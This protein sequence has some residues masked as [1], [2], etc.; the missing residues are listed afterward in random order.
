MDITIKVNDDQFNDLM[1]EGIEALSI[2][3][4]KQILINGIT[5]M[6]ESSFGKEI[7]TKLLFKK[8]YYGSDYN[9]SDTGMKILSSCISDQDFTD[10]KEI[11][12]EKL[13]TNGDD[14]L[15]DAIMRIFMQGF[16]KS[17]EVQQAISNTTEEYISSKLFDHMREY[18]NN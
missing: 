17:T 14:I 15:S 12:M 11:L 8:D 5:Q 9:L 6:F 16:A 10:L 2:E 1:K 4:K 13:R 3:D 18:H 7:L